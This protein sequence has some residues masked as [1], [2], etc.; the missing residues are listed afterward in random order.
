MNYEE[1]EAIHTKVFAAWAVCPTCGQDDEPDLRS[2]EEVGA[3]FE[4]SAT[5]PSDHR[6]VVRYLPG[7]E[8]FECEREE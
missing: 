2:V 8:T 3:H 6:W 7:S 1:L 5:C 4:F